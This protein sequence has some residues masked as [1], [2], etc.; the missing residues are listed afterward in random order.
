MSISLPAWRQRSAWL[1]STRE[2]WRKHS[3]TSDT[4]FTVETENKP[5]QKPAPVRMPVRMWVTLLVALACAIAVAVWWLSPSTPDP[6]YQGKPLSIWLTQ[7]NTNALNW[8]RHEN[9][10]DEAVREIGT[11]G[12]PLIAKLLRA[13]D[14]PRKIRLIL[15]LQRTF[16]AKYVPIATGIPSRQQALNALGALG[17]EAKPLV[18][19]LASGI[20]RDQIL[21]EGYSAHWLQSIGPDGEAAIP[22]II[23]KLQD[24]NRNMGRSMDVFTLA[25]IS[26]RQTNIVFPVLRASL[27]DPDVWVRTTATNVL[28]RPPWAALGK[29]VLTN[30]PDAPSTTPRQQTDNP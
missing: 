21:A 1:F 24:T 7:Y 8:P 29:S 5:A 13:S 16:H 4:F 6:V 26:V 2:T 9:S 19:V 23:R 17:K 22:V 3:D 28:M 10:A 30:L 20:D 14:S 25:S 11:N 18:P 12:F 27:R 15:F